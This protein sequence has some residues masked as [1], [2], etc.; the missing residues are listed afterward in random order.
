MNTVGGLGTL[1]ARRN[2]GNMWRDGA[3]VSAMHADVGKS[4]AKRGW[5]PNGNDDGTRKSGGNREEVLAYWCYAHSIT[6]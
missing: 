4:C 2:M 5:E 1:L 6:T 3:T